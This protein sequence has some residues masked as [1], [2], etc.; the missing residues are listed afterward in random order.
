MMFTSQ[1]LSVV[2]GALLLAALVG[3][4]GLGDISSGDQAGPGEAV[5]FSYRL[6]ARVNAQGEIIRD[7]AISP[8]GKIAVTAGDTALCVWSL[9]EGKTLRKLQVLPVQSEGRTGGILFFPDGMQVATYVNDRDC[10]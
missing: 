2:F 5:R 9:A 8:D 10:Y 4:S 6:R 7:V 1:R 3:Y